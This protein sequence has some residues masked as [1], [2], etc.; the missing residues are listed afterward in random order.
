MEAAAIA[1]RPRDRTDR[2]VAQRQEACGRERLEDR[3]GAR[4]IGGL[5]VEVEGGELRGANRSGSTLQDEDDHGTVG[6][7]GAFGAPR[8]WTF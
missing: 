2:Q 8:Q 5:A 1:R 3:P 4:T 6:I 7:C